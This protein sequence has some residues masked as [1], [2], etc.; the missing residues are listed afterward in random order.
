MKNILYAFLLALLP[1]TAHASEPLKVTYGLYA[2]GFNVVEIDGTYTLSKNKYD[3]EMDLKTAGVLGRLAPWAGI[4]KTSGINKGVKS[5]PLEHSFASTWRSETETT[6]YTFKKDGSLES[7]FLVEGGEAPKDKTPN[8]EVLKGN[9]IDMLSAMFRA[10]NNPSCETTQPG[11]DRKRRFD[12]AFRSKGFDVLE[13]SRYSVFSGEAEICEIEI[14]PVAGKWREKPRG[15]MSIQGQAKE[16]GQL[17]RLWFGK[18]RD[19]MPPIPVR[20]LIKTNYG[21]MIM[22]L[23]GI[24]S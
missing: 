19:N 8:D 21:T 23:K 6:T 12:M 18:V 3:L 14:V 13:Q 1:I 9:P 11:F 4:I 2:G 16:N 7:A 10:M 17:P 22:H 20:F 15:W 24:E 5:I